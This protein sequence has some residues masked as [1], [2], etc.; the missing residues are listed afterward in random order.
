MNI[1]GKTVS[2][3]GYAALALLALGAA[4]TGHMI[5]QEMG[6]ALAGAWTTADGEAAN[7]G[8]A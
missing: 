8:P 4:A 2:R 6:E 1:M 7:G 5:V 3:L